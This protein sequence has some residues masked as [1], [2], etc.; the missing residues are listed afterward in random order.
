MSAPQ[1]ARPL[2]VG[3]IGT[4]RVGAV[5]GAALA[6]AGHRVVAASG[7]LRRSLDRAARLLPGVPAAARRRGRCAAADL[8]LLAVP[9]DVLAGA[10]RRPGRDR[11]LAPAASWSCTPPARTA[12]PCWRPPPGPARC[13]S[14]L[15]PAMT[16]T[17]TPGGPRTGWPALRSASPPP[18]DCGRRAEA[19][20]V[21]MGGEPVWVAEAARPLYHAAS[22]I[23]ANHLV[24]L[25]DEAA[26]L[27]ARAGVASPAGCS[28]RC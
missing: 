1:R 25:V 21:E 8:V 11:G 2:T 4:G 5:L 16:F 10:R 14:P 6:A 7:R 28:A 23:G 15:H 3:L 26:D 27:L 18:E 19:L 20:V 17:G 22:S 24:T 12:S 13:R 9:D